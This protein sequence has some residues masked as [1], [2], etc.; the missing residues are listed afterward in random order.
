MN[1]KFEYNPE[2]YWKSI[3]TLRW[4][5]LL[6]GIIGTVF[7]ISINYIDLKLYLIGF[8]LSFLASL[9]NSTSKLTGIGFNAIASAILIIIFSVFFIST[10]YKIKIPEN[11]FNLAFSMSLAAGIV[12]VIYVKLKR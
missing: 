2:K 8:A 12:A 10:N 7:L 1:N 6:A 3:V 9:V 11:M 5:L 4:G